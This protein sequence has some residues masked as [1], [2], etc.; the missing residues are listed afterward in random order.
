MPKASKPPAR[1]C[2]EVTLHFRDE[3]LARGMVDAT[4]LDEDGVWLVTMKKGAD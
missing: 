3:G 4:P 1:P 2:F